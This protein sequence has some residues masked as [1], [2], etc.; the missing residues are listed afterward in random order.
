MSEA[1]QSSLINNIYVPYIRNVV[2]IFY[3]FAK[4][5]EGEKVWGIKIS[6]PVPVFHDQLVLILDEFVAEFPEL[7]QLSSETISTKYQWV[8][9]QG[10][11]KFMGIWVVGIQV[12]FQRG[13]GLISNNVP[14]DFEYNNRLIAFFIKHNMPVELGIHKIVKGNS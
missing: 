7:I 5:R 13:S 14:F 1:Q 11:D 3:K 10:L 12:R 4:A 6:T 2:D 8:T 9:T